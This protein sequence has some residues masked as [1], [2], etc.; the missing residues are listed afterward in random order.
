MFKRIAAI[1]FILFCTSVAWFILAGT[2]HSRTFEVDDRLRP[3]VASIWG[4]PQEQRPPSAAYER[5]DQ[6]IIHTE[7]DG[8]KT[9]RTEAHRITV[10]LPVESSRIQV[11]LTLDHRQKG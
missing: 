4:S 1:S 6:A 11:G 9:T 10:P 8:H 2:I 7:T 3:V 5:I